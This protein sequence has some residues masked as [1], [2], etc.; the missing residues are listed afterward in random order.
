MRS[1]K[2]YVL[3]KSFPREMPE[4]SKFLFQNERGFIIKTD[5]KGAELLRPNALLISG[6]IWK[7]KTERQPKVLYSRKVQKKNGMK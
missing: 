7:L 4:D 3:V 2:R 1:K 5:M 6:S